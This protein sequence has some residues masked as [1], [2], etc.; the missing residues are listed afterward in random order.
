MN[1]LHTVLRL[2]VAAAMVCS[3]LPGIIAAP[4]SAQAV[5]DFK[6][7]TRARM[8][9]RLWNSGGVGQPTLGGDE[10]YK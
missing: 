3:L 9:A 10:Y 2:V 6:D 1:A 4:A 8:W 7:L 5:F